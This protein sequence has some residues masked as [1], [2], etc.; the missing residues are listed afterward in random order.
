[1]VEEGDLP[2]LRRP[3][4]PLLRRGL[5]LRRRRL[6]EADRSATCASEAA[7][8]ALPVAF[9]EE[10]ADRAESGARALDRRRRRGRPRRSSCSSAGSATPSSPSG[11]GH[12]DIRSLGRVRN[13]LAE[14]G[15]VDAAL[16]T[17][18]RTL[19]FSGDQ[20]VRYSGST[21][22]WVDEGYPAEI[23]ASLPRELGI[24]G[25]ARP[26]S[27]TASTRRSR[28]RRRPNDPV[29]RR[30]SSLHRRRHRPDRADRGR[31]GRGAQ[32]VRASGAPV[33]A[34]FVGPDGELYVF[35]GDQY[36]R[37]APGEPT[38]RRRGLPP[39]DQGRLGQPA[40]GLRGGHR[41]ARSSSRAGPTS[42]RGPSTSATPATGS[43]RS[44]GPC[45]SRS[46]TAGRTRPTT[47]WPTCAPSP[48]SSSW[49]G[50]TREMPAGSP[51]C[52]SPDSDRVADPYAY[53]A[54][55]FG[56]DVDE[57]RWCRRHSRF[58][59]GAADDEDRFELEFL[60]ETADL[61]RFAGSLGS[62]PSRLRETVWTRIYRDG[63]R[64]PPAATPCTRCLSARDP[65]A[66]RRAARGDER[67]PPGRPGAGG[68]RARRRLR[69][70]W[71]PVRAI[72]AR[73]GDGRRGD[74]VPGPGGD[75][76]DPALR[77][78]LPAQPGAGGRR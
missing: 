73:R 69:H 58:L 9:D 35:A 13:I 53:V 62:T 36:V 41:R 25:P 71:R 37:Y 16:V 55:L 32:R 49:P 78:P 56:W 1:M 14:R 21:T 20:Y 3:V 60:L 8:A 54:G 30:A 27:P 12:H 5:P 29:R 42:A 66:A 75:R 39:L 74:H 67:G 15:R 59:S 40:G 33:D 64:S 68:A 34:A 6:P 48:G 17:G 23:G 28:D 61:F 72:P 11:D 70:A 63:R 26:S 24:A 57:L 31:V 4:R 51:G 38:L 77:A 2:V 52:C 7:F 50:P 46:R 44:T 19:L 65:A 45:R 43:T 10:L 22:A 18:G 76:G 47:G